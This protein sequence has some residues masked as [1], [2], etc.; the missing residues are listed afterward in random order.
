[1]RDRIDRSGWFKSSH[2]ADNPA[3]VE[4]RFNAD[5]TDVRDSKN[6]AGPVLSFPRAAWAKFLRR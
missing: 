4:I 1:M 6:A 5:T 2:S 3:C